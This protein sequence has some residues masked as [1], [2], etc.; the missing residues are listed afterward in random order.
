MYYC[1]TCEKWSVLE[2]WREFLEEGVV[3]EIYTFYVCCKSVTAHRT[4][5]KL[6]SFFCWICG[7]HN[8]CVHLDYSSTLKMVAICSSE[9]SLDFQETTWRYNPE[10]RT[11]LYVFLLF[12]FLYY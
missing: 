8:G 12:L 11:L 4:L 7:S 3:G 10:D 5:S 1:V 2:F 6:N 9:T